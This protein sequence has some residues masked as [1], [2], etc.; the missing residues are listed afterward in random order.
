MEYGILI[1]TLAVLAILITAPVGAVGISLAGPKFLDR[2]RMR[3]DG[4]GV[5]GD[6]EDV[7]DAPIVG[8]DVAEDE[9]DA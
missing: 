2:R 1:V 7:N 9:S 5:G 4:D 6:G 3:G 8:G